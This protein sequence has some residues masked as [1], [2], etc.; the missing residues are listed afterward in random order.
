MALARLVSGGF[1]TALGGPGTVVSS[2]GNGDSDLDSGKRFGVVR[3]FS[4]FTI[5]SP[6]TGRTSFGGDALTWRGVTGTSDRRDGRT[7]RLT[8]GSLRGMG[9]AA[10]WSS[11]E[12]SK[13]ALERPSFA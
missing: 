12:G 5:F 4:R 7:S 11:G 6:A 9:V 13:I 8:S 2:D 3:V 10:T 1:T